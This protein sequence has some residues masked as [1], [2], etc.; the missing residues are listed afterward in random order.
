LFTDGLQPLKPSQ[1]ADA[2][3]RDLEA[4]ADALERDGWRFGYSRLAVVADGAGF[5]RRLRLLRALS[6][7]MPV[8]TDL[9]RDLDARAAAAIRPIRYR[10]DVVVSR[11]EESGGGVRILGESRTSGEAGVV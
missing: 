9:Q 3:M 7:R 8:R 11:V 2:L 10:P 6:L 5:K 1:Q 4:N